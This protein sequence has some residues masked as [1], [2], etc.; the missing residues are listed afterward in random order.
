MVSKKI[1]VML[2]EVGGDLLSTV[3]SVEEMQAHLELV[4]TAW[5]MSLNTAAD[6]KKLLKAFI[7]KQKR[8]AP[9][10]AA[11]KGLEWEIRRI[12]KQKDNLFP[13]IKNK[14]AIA[15]AIDNGNDNYVIRAYFE[16]DILY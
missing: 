10:E 15:E 1:S 7:K 11:L 12:K 8:Y 14:V 5:N 6:R 2:I 16:E 3:T 4:K 13:D 9:S